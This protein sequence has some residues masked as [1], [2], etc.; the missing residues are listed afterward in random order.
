MYAFANFY[1]ILKHY[2][3]IFNIFEAEPSNKILCTIALPEI[4]I[5]TIILNKLKRFAYTN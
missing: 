1:F 3:T 2:G 4:I 5:F